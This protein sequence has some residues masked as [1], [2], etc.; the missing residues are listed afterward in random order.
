MSSVFVEV[1]LHSLFSEILPQKPRLMWR[2]T[3]LPESGVGDHGIYWETL[4]PSC[5]HVLHISG[6]PILVVREQFSADTTS[7]DCAIPSSSSSNAKAASELTSNTILE[8]ES[9]SLV[10]ELMSQAAT[11]RVE[12]SGVPR[13][14]ECPDGYSILGRR[15]VALTDRAG[16]ECPEGEEVLAVETEAEMDQVES[17]LGMR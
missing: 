3:S 10:V 11:V 4:H 16:Q 15:C 7:T 17:L 13:Y 12:Y 9:S 5:H 8:S 14:P 2:V 6:E 1:T